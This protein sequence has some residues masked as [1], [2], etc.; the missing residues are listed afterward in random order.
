[1]EIK[2]MISADFGQTYDYTAVAVTERRL[3]Q[4][5][6]RYQHAEE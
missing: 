3:V 4:V 6:E 2:Y 1:M 5:G